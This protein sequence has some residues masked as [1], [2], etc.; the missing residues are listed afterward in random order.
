MNLFMKATSKWA[1]N[2]RTPKASDNAEAARWRKSISLVGQQHREEES[3][4]AAVGRLAYT[5]LK[6]KEPDPET[7]STLSQMVHWGYG[8]D[9]GMLYGVTRGPVSGIDAAGGLAFGAGLW[10]AGDELAVPLLGLAESPL[11]YPPSVH[12]RALGAHLLYGLVTAATFQ[13]LSRL[14]KSTEPKP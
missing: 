14:G 12:L 3:A 2:D 11:S 4:T 7:K 6:R 1:G 10:F 8:M 13:T 5:A 9:M